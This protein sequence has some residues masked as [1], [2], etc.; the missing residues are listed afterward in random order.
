MLLNS[1]FDVLRGWPKEGALDETFPVYSPGGVPV[2]LPAGS[3]IYVRSDGYANLASSAANV[4]KGGTAPTPTW[5]VV[6]G[7]DDFSGQFTNKVVAIRA[8]AM[9]RLDPAN[10]DADSYPPG[11]P[12]TFTSGL[13]YVCTTNKQVIGEAIRDDQ[14]VD[15]TI[16]VYYSGGI[17]ALT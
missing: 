3:V 2:A 1:K 5:V 11:T 4:S 16:V 8:N 12:L 10:F 13:F 15:G 9:L 17:A 7:N 14:S 6:E